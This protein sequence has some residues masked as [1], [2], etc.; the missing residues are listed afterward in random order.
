MGGRI[1][2]RELSNF[3]A[4]LERT[5]ETVEQCFTRA[6]NTCC[7]FRPKDVYCTVERK[8]IG[9]NGLSRRCHTYEK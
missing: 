2:A 7:S 9:L 6:L 5:R 1:L 3:D 8:G 4:G